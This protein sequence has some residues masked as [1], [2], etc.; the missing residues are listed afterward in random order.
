MSEVETFRLH[1]EDWL[2]ASRDAWW[3]RD[4]LGLI[5]SRFG[6]EEAG[7][8]LDVGS[9]KGHWG[10]ALVGALTDRAK[11]TGVDSE[12]E[13]NS[14]AR[15]RAERLGLGERAEYLEGTAEALPFED[16]GFDVVTC[17]TLLIHLRE[18]GSAIAEMLRVLRPGGNLLLVEPNNQAAQLVR[19]SVSARFPLERR[20]SA[21]RFHLTCEAG[22]AALGEGDNSL[23][24]LLPGLL[25]ARGVEGIQAYLADK[26]FL[27]SPPYG[28]EERMI[29]AEQLELIERRMA[30]WPEN[31]AKRYFLAGGGSE[32]QFERE[33]ERRLEEN[34]R[35]KD[36]IEAESFWSAG[37]SIMYLIGGRKPLAT[38]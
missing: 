8:V 38:R 18:P 20:L 35:V 6:I 3:N 19:N 10:Q 12:P 31:E 23:G 7:R 9:G 21:L 32:E 15:E 27:V 26:T 22:K 28:S 5:A 33:W 37:G 14:A 34:E 24:D 4:F 17:Q 2:G 25:T 13:W 36:A 16:A 30:P 11:L 29:L 1:S